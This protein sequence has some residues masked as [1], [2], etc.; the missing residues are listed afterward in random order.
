[1]VLCFEVG[2]FAPSVTLKVRGLP[3]LG[4]NMKAKPIDV[5]LMRSLLEYAPELGGSCLMWK[6]LRRGQPK[7]G[8]PAGC[9]TR[10][11]YWT[12]GVQGK[13]YLAHR[14][15]WAIVNGE[16][17]TC[18]ID[19]VHGREAGNH[20]ENLRL[21]PNDDKDNQQNRKKYRNNTSGFMG[22]SWAKRDKKWRAQI[23]AN[24][25]V[26]ALGTFNTPEEAYEVYLKAKAKM[27]AFNP[28]PR[29]IHG[30]SKVQE[31]L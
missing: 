14:L 20:I 11:G 10:D 1:M 26:Y 4:E 7:I 5:E 27:H 19:H 23:K 13:Q 17:P 29:G 24:K 28:T 15:V 6:A 22:V 16:D 25:K 9:R 31:V 12:V 3:T 30:D 18:Q 8:T 21:A 2:Y